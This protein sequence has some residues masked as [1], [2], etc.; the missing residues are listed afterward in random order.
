MTDVLTPIS[1]FSCLFIVQF[2]EQFKVCIYSS[3][4]DGVLSILT[5]MHTQLRFISHLYGTEPLE[6][7]SAIDKIREQ[8][9]P[10]DSF[11]LKRLTNNVRTISNQALF[12][13]S[14]PESHVS[15][16]IT[17][18]L[19]ACETAPKA[20][21]NVTPLKSEIEA[22]VKQTEEVIENVMTDI[23]W[24]PA[25]LEGPRFMTDTLRDV[26]YKGDWSQAGTRI[27]SDTP[28]Y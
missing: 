24:D 2:C 3:F 12:S 1:K 28:Q 6:C 15:N 20:T 10:S 26:L 27:T 14:F 9:S 11:M 19:L 17:L 25:V 4:F 21:P 22:P 16:S 8:Y 7:L 18:T 23:P 5:R 13:P